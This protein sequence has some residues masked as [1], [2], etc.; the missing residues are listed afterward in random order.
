[1]GNAVRHFICGHERVPRRAR[2]LRSRRKERRMYGRGGCGVARYRGEHR[3]HTCQYFCLGRER[4]RGGYAP[5]RGGGKGRRGKNIC[6]RFRV[7]HNND[8]VF[9]VVSLACPRGKMQKAENGARAL[10]RRRVF[11]VAL[12]AEKHRRLCLSA[13]GALRR[14][15]SCRMR[16]EKFPSEK[17]SPLH[18]A[19]G[20]EG[21]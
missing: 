9:V 13:F 1:M 3:D 5:S 21:I 17:N 8:A 2:R 14:I 4:D 6:S 10:M 11:P 15:V 20:R 12:R 7:R 19:K 18:G 16:A